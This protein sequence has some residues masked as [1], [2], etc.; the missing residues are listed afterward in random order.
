MASEI[1]RAPV[2]NNQK[3]P[4][5]ERKHRNSRW[6]EERPGMSEAHLECVRQLPCVICG[7]VGRG[8]P[9]HLRIASE[10][11]MS[12]KAPDKWAVPMCRIHHDEAHKVGTKVENRW[13]RERGIASPM[14]LAAALWMNTGDIERMARIV[15]AHRGE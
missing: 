1:Y 4:R 8:D 5:S 7:K 6:R 13:F 12:V 2:L 11:G 3:P 10:R 9:H 14:D 15:S